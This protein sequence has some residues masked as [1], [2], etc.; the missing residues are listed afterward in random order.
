MVALVRFVRE[1]ASS[2]AP[3]L[4][5]PPAVERERAPHAPPPGGHVA[6]LDGIRGLAI[7]LVMLTHFT[8]VHSGPILDR[9][10]GTAGRF[11]WSGVD[12]FF[13]LSGF[14]ITGILLDAKGSPNFLRH[15]YA[16]RALRIFP[17]YFAFLF[18]ATLLVPALPFA[19][20]GLFPVG[21]WTKPLYWLYLS[22]FAITISPD[23]ANDMLGPTWSLAIEEQFYLAW[24]LLVLVLSRRALLWTCGLG[25][26]LSVA[27][28]TAFVTLGADRL[29]AYVLTPCRMDGL[30]IGCL[31]AIVLRDGSGTGVIGRARELV[32]GARVLSTVAGLTILAIIAYHRTTGFLGGP[33]QA[34]GHTVIAA[35]FAGLLVMT[36]ASPRAGWLTRF[37][38]QRWLRT[39]GKYSYALYLFHMVIHRL[40]REYVYG[41]EDFHTL[42]GSRLPGQLVFYAIC[43]SLSLAAA[44]VSWHVLEKHFLRLKRLFPTHPTTPVAEP[45]QGSE[46]SRLKFPAL[47]A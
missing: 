17:L 41:L 7:L 37:F 23:V 45:W 14:L 43:T 21:D 46:A 6:A 35:L 10:V 24:P 12:L 30:A 22:N 19:W 1:P 33:G 4:P 9:L 26:V 25:V 29:W 5:R 32:R 36:L 40:V 2:R 27:S 39:L 31:V 34:V 18:L 44:W 47:A 13:V 20:T 42:M 15:F 3:L 11:G 38:T 28:R 16:R 8:L